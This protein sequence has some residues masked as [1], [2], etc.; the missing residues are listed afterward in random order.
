MLPRISYFTKLDYFIVG[1]NILVFLALLK[2]VMSSAI[3]RND[4][5][6]IA[7]KLDQ[8]LRYVF[9]ILYTIVLLITFLS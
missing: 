9:P 4:K 8:H 2:A 7:R 5:E 3:A 6:K 1:S